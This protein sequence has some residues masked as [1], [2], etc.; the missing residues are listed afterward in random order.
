MCIGC[1]PNLAG[2]LSVIASAGENIAFCRQFA[3]RAD[4]AQLVEHF[5]R[6]RVARP[7]RLREQRA[8]SG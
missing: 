6:K 2:T 7:G 1:A 5:T 3:G 4:V 8:G